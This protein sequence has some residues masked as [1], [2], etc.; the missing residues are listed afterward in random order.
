MIF[1]NLFLFQLF[2]RFQLELKIVAKFELEHINY[3]QKIFLS[4]RLQN[5]ADLTFDYLIRDDNLHDRFYEV[6][7]NILIDFDR[8]NFI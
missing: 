5:Q 3:M 4:D 1:E 2:R 6:L 7:R 8:L